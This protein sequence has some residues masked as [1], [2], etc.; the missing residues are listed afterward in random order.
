[1]EKE[2][3]KTNG[4]VKQHTDELQDIQITIDNMEQYSRKT[5]LEFCG[6]PEEVDMS[7]DQVVCKIAE[8]ISVQIQVDDVEISRR[9]KHK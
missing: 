4:Y 9:I 7:T 5:S 2:L 1:M 6:I 8:A 3:S